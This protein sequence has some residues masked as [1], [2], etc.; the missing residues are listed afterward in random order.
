M[1]RPVLLL[2]SYRVSIYTYLNYTRKI[3]CKM[4]A[5]QKDGW[6]EGQEGTSSS[7]C[8]VSFNSDLICLDRMGREMVTEKKKIPP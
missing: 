6:V 7:G 5:M 4:G 8:L 3:C 2:R 1:F